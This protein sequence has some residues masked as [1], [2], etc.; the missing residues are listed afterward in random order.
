MTDHPS[1]TVLLV[2]DVQE[3]L[4]H[5]SSPI[6]KADELIFNIQSLIERAHRAA[7]PVIYIQHESDKVLPKGSDDWQLHHALHPQENELIIY[8]QHGSSFEQTCLD[9][10]LHR[11]GVTR[12]VIC[13]LVTHGCVRAGCLDALKLGYRVTLA[14]D[15]HSNYA[16]DAINHIEKWNNTLA[17]EGAEV[18][19]TEAIRF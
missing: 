18:I 16:K 7:V 1:S 10:E 4:F 17:E 2:I 13:G 14:S 6:Y 11:Q 9:D 3:G 5:K 12:L 8:K 19:K 15:A